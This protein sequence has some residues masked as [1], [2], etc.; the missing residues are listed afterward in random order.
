VSLRP[1]PELLVALKVGEVGEIRR[2]ILFLM[3]ERVAKFVRSV[4][5]SWERLLGRVFQLLVY[6]QTY[7]RHCLVL[8]WRGWRT[9]SV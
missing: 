6:L 3:A 1:S 4:K 8:Y 5:Y 2:M 9:L 7:K